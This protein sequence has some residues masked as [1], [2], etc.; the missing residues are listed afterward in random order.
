MSDFDHR[1]GVREMNLVVRNLKLRNITEE[2][3]DNLVKEIDEIFGIDEVSY[4][5]SAGEIHLAYDASN[6]NLDGIEEVIRKHGADIHDDW[7][8]H[9]K[10]GYY[11]FVDQNVKNKKIFYIRVGNTTRDLD[12]EQTVNFINM[13][14]N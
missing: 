12:S 5:I 3:C 4:N 10:E 13:N 14:W 8:T 11:K 6:I 2:N 7:W 1:V 9:T